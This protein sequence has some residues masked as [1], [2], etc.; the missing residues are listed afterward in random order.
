[1]INATKHIYSEKPAK[2]EVGT[3]KSFLVR[4]KTLHAKYQALFQTFLHSL[5]YISKISE[6]WEI[7]I[8]QNGFSV[9]LREFSI[10]AIPQGQ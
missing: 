2:S 5:F 3:P 7:S 6:N 1:M 10:L 9:D 4:R 8:F